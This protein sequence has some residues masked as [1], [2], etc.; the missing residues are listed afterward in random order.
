MSKEAGLVD[1][2]KCVGRP[3]WSLIEF[4]DSDGGDSAIMKDLF[5]QECLKRGIL[6][7]NT[8]NISA[9]HDSQ[10]IQQTL[11]AY[12]EVIKTLASWIH[13]PNPSRFLE[14]SPSRPIFRVR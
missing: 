1:R 11:E 9:A 7:H 2:V 6:I 14:G 5:Q 12:A 3:T 13:D 10:D 8:H 4:S